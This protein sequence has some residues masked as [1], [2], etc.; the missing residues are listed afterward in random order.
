MPKDRMIVGIMTCDG[1]MGLDDLRDL[2]VGLVQVI[3]WGVGVDGGFERQ[4]IGK[5]FSISSHDV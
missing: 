5:E 2:D 1:C 4:D 3:S